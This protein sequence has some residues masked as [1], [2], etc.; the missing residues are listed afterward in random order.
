M[1]YR[2]V[3]ALKGRCALWGRPRVDSPGDEGPHD[4]HGGPRCDREAAGGQGG[5][6]KQPKAAKGAK[7]AAGVGAAAD[8]PSPPARP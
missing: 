4:A 7:A 3:C 6:A 1:T 5:D 2:G 8:N